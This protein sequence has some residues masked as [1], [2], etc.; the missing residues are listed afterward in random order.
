[1]SCG[2]RDRRVT[3]EPEHRGVTGGSGKTR[4]SATRLSSPANIAKPDLQL[5]RLEGF[6][7]LGAVS[8][9]ILPAACRDDPAEAIGRAEAAEGQ[10]LV[11]GCG[12]TDFIRTGEPGCPD[13]IGGDAEGILEPRRGFGGRIGPA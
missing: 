13:A 10:I 5:G 6:Q 8:R 11:G 3:R 1:M 12:A 4:R 2:R 7:G 9:G